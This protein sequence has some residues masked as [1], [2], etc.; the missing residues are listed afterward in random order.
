M[1]LN[2]PGGQGAR[3]PAEMKAH[4]NWTA[5]AVRE[6]DDAA[7][8]GYGPEWEEACQLRESMAALKKAVSVAS[9]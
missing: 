5:L 6:D 2:L 1:P 3:V 8:A 4:A 7:A 9:G